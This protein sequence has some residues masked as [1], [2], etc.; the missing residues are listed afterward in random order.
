MRAAILT[1]YGDVDKIELRDVPEPLVEPNA[2]KV[3]VA[4]AGINPVDWKMRAGAA[5]G[6]MP[7]GVPAI[8]GRD[9]SGEV[10][11][12]GAAILN[13]AAAFKVG[14]RVMGLVNEA[15]AEFVVASTDAWATVPDG[16]DLVE[17]AALP[18]VLLTGT[19]L[20]DEA[21]RPREGDVL[22]VTGAVGGVGRAAV[23]AARASGA[24]VW[25]G[26]RT[27]QRAAAAELGAHGVVALDDDS[28]IARLPRL[29][30]I[31]DTLGGATI[32]KLLVK[33]KPKGTVG[34]VVGEPAGARDH[35]LIVQAMMA[36]PDGKR[37][38]ALAQAV[39]ERKLLVPIARTFPLARVREAQRLAEKGG[40]GGKVLLKM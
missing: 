16:L 10:V 35:G 27:T 31:A 14:A 4:A 40:A 3:R 7:H 25:A 2:I 13:G 36:H 23:H 39:A 18:L 30:G 6:M 17:A 20:I 37:L 26:V 24:Q 19:Q 1:A 38:A 34:S 12:V 29:D 11:E 21:V 15:Y 22:L 33:V 32:Q 8:L 28:D 5:K 9:A